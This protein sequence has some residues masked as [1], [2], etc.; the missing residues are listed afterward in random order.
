MNAS[1]AQ[2]LPEQDLVRTKNWARQPMFQSMDRC[3]RA[4]AATTDEDSVRVIRHVRSD[5]FVDLRGL[6]AGLAR[7]KS[8]RSRRG[9]S[10]A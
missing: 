7:G 4:Q 6:D 3:N 10:G 5:P 1:Q 8:D 9:Y 2:C